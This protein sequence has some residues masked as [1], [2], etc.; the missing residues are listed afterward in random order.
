MP[1]IG[2]DNMGNAGKREVNKDTP[3]VEGR[4]LWEVEWEK[5]LSHKEKVPWHSLMEWSC[6]H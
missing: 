3:L 6:L 4:V 1:D 5:T 2:E